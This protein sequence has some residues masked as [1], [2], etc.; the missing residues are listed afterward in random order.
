MNGFYSDFALELLSSIDF[1]ASS[2]KTFSRQEL[3]KQII[4]DKLL[5][6]NDRK[7]SVFS[8]PK[9]IDISLRHIKNAG[10]ENGMEKSTIAQ[11]RV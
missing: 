10:I 11:H 8:N 7:Q 6:W 9:Y 4:S 5:G 1:L 3:D 2:E